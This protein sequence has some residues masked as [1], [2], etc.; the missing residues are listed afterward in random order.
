[1]FEIGAAKKDITCFIKGMGMFGYGMHSHIVKDIE[2]RLYAR[3]FTFRESSTGKKFAYVCAEILSITTAVRKGVINKLQ[4]EYAELGY[5]ADNVMLA[6]THTHSA[7]GGYSH[8]A[9]YNITIPGFAPKVY[10]TLV[11]GMVEAIIEAD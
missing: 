3:A 7:P 10:D 5:F 6:G 11:N 9:L 4:Q 1:M 2:T 8:Y